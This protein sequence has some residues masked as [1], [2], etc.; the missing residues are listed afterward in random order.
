PPRAGAIAQAPGRV[1]LVLVTVQPLGPPDLPAAQPQW[2]DA[3]EAGH[4]RGRPQDAGAVLGGAPRRPAV[5]RAAAGVKDGCD[6]RRGCHASSQRGRSA[7]DGRPSA[8][9]V[10]NEWAAWRIEIAGPAPER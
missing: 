9:D 5:A 4:R 10:C 6:R 3:Q 8:E 7:P 2:L 1:R